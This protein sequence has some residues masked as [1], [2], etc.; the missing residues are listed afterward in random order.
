VDLG[1]AGKSVLVTGGTRGIGLAIVRRLAD[2][3]A[4]V[5]FCARDPE[6][7]ARVE[8]ELAP[9]A[10]RVRG[11]ALDVTEPGAAE[12]LLGECL[13]A[14]DRLDGV[15]A[16]AG[17]AVG[18]P[19]LAASTDADWEAT[20][21]W[22][23]VHAAGLVR[24]ARAALA[25]RGGAAVLIGSIS[26]ARPSPWPQYAA[27]KAAQEAVARSLAAELA[28]DRIRV[29]CVRPG[30]IRFAGG[31]WEGYAAAEPDAYARFVEQ[32]LP[33]QALGRPEHVADVVAFAVSPRAEWV[34]GAVIAVD[35]A[36]RGSSPYPEADPHQ[37]G[38]A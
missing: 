2:E 21:R 14:F 29:N 12:R 23:V 24:A 18:S 20:Y 28:P 30:S 1:L 25:R 13:T 38:P 9:A 27:A 33:W 26:A 17:G 35:G 4:D 36:Q 15:V 8:R 10:G 31:A 32:E 5:T 3:G 11:V 22:N 34:N 7:V 6:G 16:N 37:E 19:T